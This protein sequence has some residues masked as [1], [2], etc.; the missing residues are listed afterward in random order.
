MGAAVAKRGISWGCNDG[1]V[2]REMRA[3][4]RCLLWHLFLCDMCC[5]D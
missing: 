2:L 4:W 3:T 1:T 5:A